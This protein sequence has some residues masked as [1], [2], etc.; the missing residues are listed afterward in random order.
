MPRHPARPEM[1][2]RPLA[3][4]LALALAVTSAAAADPAVC[5]DDPFNVTDSEIDTICGE[6]A[7]ARAAGRVLFDRRKSLQPR[8]CLPPPGCALW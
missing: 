4:M 1:T 6:R 2:M 8:L 5:V 3:T 7:R